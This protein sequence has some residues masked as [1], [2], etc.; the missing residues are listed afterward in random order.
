MESIEVGARARSTPVNMPTMPNSSASSRPLVP[1]LIES[2][3]CSK[4]F[5]N[6][7]KL[8]HLILKIFHSFFFFLNRK[9][10]R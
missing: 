10:F 2:G 4:Y 6:R 5:K 3:S 8:S 1:V 9:F 7:I